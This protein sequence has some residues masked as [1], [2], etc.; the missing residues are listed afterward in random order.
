MFDFIPVQYYATLYYYIL[1]LVVLLTFLKSYYVALNSKQNLQA[2]KSTALFLLIFTTFY[3]GLRQVNG[4]YFGDMANYAMFF[5]NYQQGY[6]SPIKKDYVFETFMELCSKIMTVNVF[7]FI[8]AVLYILPLWSACKTWFKDYHF[9]AFLALLLSFSFWG[10]GVN[11]IRNGIATSIFLYGLSREKLK[12][13]VILILIA[14]GFH[15]SII[16]PT[17]AF[18]LTFLYKNI[19]VYLFFWLLCIPLSILSGGFWEN[20]FSRF[21]EDDRA[22]YLIEGNVNGDTFSSTGFR[23]DFV[24]Y[25]A[26]AVYSAYFFIIRKNFMD[27]K[28]NTLV[29]IYLT[30]N[31]FWILVIR[32]NFSNRFAYLSWFMMAIII[33]YPFLTKIQFEK[34][35]KVLCTVLLVYFSFTFLMNVILS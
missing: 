15:K 19:K 34:Q 10:Y 2:K 27:E 33:F 6:T 5:E 23:W 35:H 12:Y 18:S 11:G 20:L 26:A 14:I 28:Y 3:I 31:A 4:A 30:S 29:C 7:F 1:L 21:M 17:A 16:I 22:S 24:I 9:Y 13:K 25:S 32:A 8:C